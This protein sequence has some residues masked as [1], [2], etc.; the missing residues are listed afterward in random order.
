MIMYPIPSISRVYLL[1]IQQELVVPQPFTTNSIIF[2][3]KN[4]DFIG[5]SKGIGYSKTHMLCTHVKKTIHIIDDCYFKHELP[6]GYQT[7]NQTI[8]TNS[9]SNNKSPTNPAHPSDKE[10]FISKEDY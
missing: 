9:H 7:R 6:L 8:C 10:G 2:V 4:S 5:C 3:A 1:I